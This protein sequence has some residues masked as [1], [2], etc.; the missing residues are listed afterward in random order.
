MVSELPRPI[1]K[2]SNAIL[3]D[4][5]VSKFLEQFVDKNMYRLERIYN[6]MYRDYPKGYDYEE[7][8]KNM[9]NKFVQDGLI[10][11]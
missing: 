1:R 2:E 10:K 6:R 8:L 7:K 4:H 9:M 11:P 3:T 5:V